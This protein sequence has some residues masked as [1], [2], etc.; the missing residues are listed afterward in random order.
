MKPTPLTAA[1]CSMGVPARWRM[2]IV[3]V[4]LA[5]SLFGCSGAAIKP[6]WQTDTSSATQAATRAFLAGQSKVADIQFAQA[7][8]AVSSTGKLEEVIKLTL[9]RC[10]LEAAAL[11]Q[12]PCEEIEGIG[13]YMSA[14]DAAS[15]TALRSYGRYLQG[16]ALDEDE[17]RSLPSGQTAMADH[18]ALATG[19]GKAT[20]Q[21][22]LAIEQPL[23]RLVAAG[24]WLRQQPASQNVPLAVIAVAVDTAS[25]QGWRRPLAAWLALQVR[26]ARAAGDAVLER[27]ALT[28]LEVVLPASVSGAVSK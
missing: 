11:T 24:V 2:A 27:R 8:Q 20:T 9:L 21:V 25:E 26:S 7:K 19:G 13:T 16:A 12:T 4:A 22:L 6:A 17:R 15:Q 3:S 5:T 28:R 14:L 23:S 18:L 1:S 10:A